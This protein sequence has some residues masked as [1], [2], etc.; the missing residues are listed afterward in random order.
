MNTDLSLDALGL[1][2]DTDKASHA[3]DYLQV[4]AQ[5]L[6]RFRQDPINF[7][8]VGWWTGASMRM[9]RDYFTQARVVGIDIEPKDPIPGVVFEQADQTDPARLG[10]ISQGHGPW[11][12]I[13]DD[14][15]HLS[16]HTAQ[17]FMMLWPYLRPGGL[18][19]V[20]DL[21]VSYHVAWQGN[22]HP[23]KKPR[24]GPT[25]MQFLRLLADAPHHGHGTMEQVP[26]PMF[27]IHHVAFW[28]G[29]AVVQKRA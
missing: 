17:T 21:Q 10:K 6:D 25:T 22:P 12:V 26:P 29:L 14:A 1:L 4:Y 18:Y 23:D 7:L 2:H 11:D 5:Y 3:H 9:W 28:P 20:E 8:E 24:T 16:P 27:D 15:S 19:F 13:V